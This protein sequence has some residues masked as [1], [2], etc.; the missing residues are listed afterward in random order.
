MAPKITQKNV[1][2]ISNFW[3]NLIDNMTSS[4]RHIIEFI[5]KIRSPSKHTLREMYLNS[6]V[7]NEVKKVA[8]T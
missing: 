8:N 6:K 1:L 4:W 7:L 2:I 5:G 3:D